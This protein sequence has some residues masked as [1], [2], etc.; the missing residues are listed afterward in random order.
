MEHRHYCKGCND[1]D[2]PHDPAWCCGGDGACPEWQDEPDCPGD[3]GGEHEWGAADVDSL[4]GTAYRATAICKRC[5]MT[6][7][8]VDPGSER[9]PGECDRRSYNIA[10]RL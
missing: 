8:I 3:P 4:G 6:E 7:V 10:V 2:S 5:G 1:D 9:D